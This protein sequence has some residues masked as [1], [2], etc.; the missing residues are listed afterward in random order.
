MTGIEKIT[1]RI[2]ED[3]QAE[4]DALLA[5]ANGEA[6][7]IR[8]R[9]EAQAQ[10]EFDDITRHGAERAREREENLAGA[11]GLEARKAT[12]LAKQEMLD[13]AFDLAA[14]QL[15]RLPEDEYADLLVKLAADASYTG[16]EAVLLSPEDREKFGAKVVDGANARLQAEGKPGGLTLAEETRPTGGGLLLTGGKIETNC[17]FETLL[18]LTRSE[19]SG[20]AARVLFG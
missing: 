7:T 16:A 2:N 9:Y 17:T 19:L 10:R 11:A 6:D 3:A 1:G 18:R 20:E 8:A 12:L 4:I 14:E 13:R 15:A 5:R